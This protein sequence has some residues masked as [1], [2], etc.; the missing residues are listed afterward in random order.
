MAPCR[1]ESGSFICREKEK[2]TK[3]ELMRYLLAS[4]R[5]AVR[6]KM[7]YVPFTAIIF[8]EVETKKESVQVTHGD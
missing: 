6:W 3:S 4:E 1:D 8:C 7:P 5:Y 2:L